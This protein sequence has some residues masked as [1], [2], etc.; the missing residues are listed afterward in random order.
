MHASHPIPSHPVPSLPAVPAAGEVD[1]WAPA[2]ATTA[3]TTGAANDS[4]RVEGGAASAAWKGQGSGRGGKGRPGDCPRPHRRWAGPQ[5]IYHVG[6]L[7]L[8][9]RRRG[10]PAAVSLAGRGWL[11]C[12]W[13]AYH[14]VL[15]PQITWLCLPAHSAA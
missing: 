10:A 3:T 6:E 9:V 15:A 4:R 8:R 11:R 13:H 14:I 7:T 2:T 5:C 1:G 12:R